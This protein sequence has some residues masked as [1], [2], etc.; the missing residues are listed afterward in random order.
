[1]DGK[2]LKLVVN[3]GVK[4]RSGTEGEKR[5]GPAL[6]E[7]R[8]DTARMAG[9]KKL[10]SFI[11]RHAHLADASE[12]SRSQGKSGIGYCRCRQAVLPCLA[13]PILA[14]KHIIF[15]I[16]EQKLLLELYQAP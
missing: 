12:V 3:G 1:M 5:D 15:M 13:L 8:L 2:L 6:Y 9:S 4:E 16:K 7:G 10:G 11:R 14:H